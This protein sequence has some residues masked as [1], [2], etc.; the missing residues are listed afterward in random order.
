MVR[1]FCKGLLM[2]K[3]LPACLFSILLISSFSYAAQVDSFHKYRFFFDFLNSREENRLWIYSF[4]GGDTP[5]RGDVVKLTDDGFMVLDEPGKYIIQ[6]EPNKV[7][8]D[9]ENLCRLNADGTKTVILTK[10]GTGEYFGDIL[11]FSVLDKMTPEQIRKIRGVELLEGAERHLKNFRY[12]DLSRTVIAVGWNTHPKRLAKVIDPNI[13]LLCCAQ[14]IF[15]ELAK[16]G[17]ISKLR[18]LLLTD[19]NRVDFEVIAKAKNL[20]YLEIHHYE[21]RGQFSASGKI[22]NPNLKVIKLPDCNNLSDI[23]FVGACKSLEVLEIPRTKVSDLRPLSGLENLRLVNASG[24]P[25][26]H[27]PDGSLKNLDQ[28]WVMGSKLKLEQVEKFESAHPKCIVGFGW[29]RS[30][31]KLLADVDRVEIDMREGCTCCSEE[32]D[33]IPYKV[34]NTLKEVRKYSQNLSVDPNEAD[35]G[36]ID[37]WYKITFFRQGRSACSFLVGY[38]E[39]FLEYGSPRNVPLSKHAVATVFKKLDNLEEERNKKIFGR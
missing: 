9:S 5:S 18:F 14:A 28:L 29:N 31:S 19:P 3:H 36:D 16:R 30:L 11:H 6:C 37:P 1:R 13:E 38:H 15:E 27:L 10:I 22:T 35:R 25:V 33:Y 23:S 32:P 12:L 2:T 7:L 34:I 4:N 8:P 20:A 24:A 26:K 17:K 21:G 39:I